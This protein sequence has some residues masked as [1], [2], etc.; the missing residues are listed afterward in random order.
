MSDAE[1]TTASC[2]SGD[3]GV[4][5]GVFTIQNNFL[6]GAD[7]AGGRYSGAGGERPSNQGYSVVY[8]MFVPAGTF[9]VQGGAPARNAP[10]RSGITF[11]LPLDFDNN[12]PIK[13][14]VPPGN[15]TL[16]VRKI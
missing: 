8:N 13:R 5:I 10:H 15:I 9:L 12:E 14:V 16:M 2:D 4:G 7:L 1:G 11:D 3:V 6:R